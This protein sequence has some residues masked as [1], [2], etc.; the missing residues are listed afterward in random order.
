MLKAGWHATREQGVCFME[1]VAW[2]N[3]EPH[4]ASPEC[5]CPV[6]GAYAI[7]TNDWLSDEARQVLVNLIPQMVGTKS[8]LAVEVKRAQYLA[9][10][11]RTVSARHAADAAGYAADAAKSAAKSAG[12][13]AGYAAGAA[14]SAARHAAA[15]AAGYAAAAA[16]SARH[17][18]E[19]AGESAGI[20]KAAIDAI[21]GALAIVD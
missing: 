15:A 13:A 17:A 21:S 20:V 11:A 6:I 14:K 16:V 7:K 19:S 2:F 3:N 9:G 4:S 5:A 12:Y 8:S 1:A 10:V 18:A